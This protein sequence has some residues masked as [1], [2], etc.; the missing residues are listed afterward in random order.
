VLQT[1]LTTFHCLPVEAF[2]DY[3]IK[4]KTC[5]IESSKFFFGTVLAHVIIDV[6]ILVLPI[7][8]IQKLQL[9]GMQKLGIILMFMF[10]IL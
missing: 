10:G 3:T 9:P 6:A 4:N 2:W 5:A 7:V 1:F 8:Q